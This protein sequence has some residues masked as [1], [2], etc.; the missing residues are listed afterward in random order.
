[1]L[2]QRVFKLLSDS[3]SLNSHDPGAPD[4]GYSKIY[5]FARTIIYRQLGLC[6][7]SLFNYA[8]TW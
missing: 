8:I 2:I 5:G 1:M 3:E 4:R 6:E 7:I